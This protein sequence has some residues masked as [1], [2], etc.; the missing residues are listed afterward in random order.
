MATD[1]LPLSS[2]VLLATTHRYYT[3][4]SHAS[5]MLICDLLPHGMLDNGRSVIWTHAFP[6]HLLPWNLYAGDLNYSPQGHPA[7]SSPTKSLPLS[8]FALKV[9]CIALKPQLALISFRCIDFL[10]FWCSILCLCSWGTLIIHMNICV[11]ILF[12]M[13][14]HP[15]TLVW[16]WLHDICRE[17]FSYL[18]HPY[19]VSLWFAQV[20][21]KGP[22]MLD[23]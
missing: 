10:I 23:I 1:F 15:C 12:S 8:P 9:E 16:S 14:Q 2:T 4:L 18:P 3:V 20:F 13:Y 19:F 11:H 21:F 6:P 17:T 7:N 5:R 22:C